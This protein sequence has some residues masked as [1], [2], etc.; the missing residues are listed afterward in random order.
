MNKMHYNIPIYI[1]NRDRL[2]TTRNLVTH[3]ME[4]G[5]TNIHIIDNASTYGPLL[6]W[7]NVAKE[8]V[9]IHRCIENY[10]Q[11][12]LWLSGI[13]RQLSGEYVVYTDSDIE[14]NRNTPTVF[15][16]TLIEVMNTHNVD[17]VGLA[18]EY[19]DL[20]AIDA[21]KKNIAIEKRYWEKPI[22]NK[23]GLQL[24]NAPI[25]TTF[26]VLRTGMPYTWR[27]RAIRVAGEYTSRHIPW[28]GIESEEEQYYLEHADKRFCSLKTLL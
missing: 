6:D 7:Y 4:L 18:I 23:I 5:Y 26:A 1:N 15:I 8:L 3:L 25:D 28:Y 9:T 19:K 11:A 22:K 17:K 2:T 12:A 13:H 27:L 14:L 20:P 24:Y 21:N 10:G 16:N